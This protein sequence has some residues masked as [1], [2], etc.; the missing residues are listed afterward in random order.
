TAVEADAEQRNI[1][2]V[3]APPDADTVTVT[4]S[5]NN[6]T[7]TVGGYVTWSVSVP[8]ADIQ[9]LGN[10]DLTVSASV[11]NQNGNTGSGSRDITIDAN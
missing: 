10:G 8:A 9:A 6:Y 2:S 5:G 11:T 4:L 7:T 1:A 3:T